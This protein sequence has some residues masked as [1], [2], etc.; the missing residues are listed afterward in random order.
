MKYLL[1]SGKMSGLFLLLMSWM[2]DANVTWKF[3]KVEIIKHIFIRVG[4]N[5]LVSSWFKIET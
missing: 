4:S 5:I 1:I 3:L 2:L